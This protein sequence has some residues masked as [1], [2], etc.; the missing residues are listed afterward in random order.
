MTRLAQIPTHASQLRPDSLRTVSQRPD[1][2][3]YA[4]EHLE[5]Y[6]PGWISE[7]EEEPNEDVGFHGSKLEVVVKLAQK[8]KRGSLPRYSYEGTLKDSSRVSTEIRPRAQRTIHRGAR[9]PQCNCARV[10]L[11]SE[12]TRD[13]SLVSVSRETEGFR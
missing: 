8:T 4:G 13:H 11:P 6:T 12:K 5:D 2:C 10:L 3:F 7:F 9:M 1:G